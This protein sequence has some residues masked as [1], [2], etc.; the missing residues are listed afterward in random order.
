MEN[1]PQITAP[2]GISLKEN[3]K[4]YL[5]DLAA[6]DAVFAEK[7]ANPKK[8]VEECAK[9]ITGEVY[10]LAG[11]ERC[12]GVTS[13]YVYGLA[14]H[15]YDEEEVKIRPVGGFS[16]I[17]SDTEDLTEEQKAEREERVQAEMRVM[18]AERRAKDAKRK[19]REEAEAVQADSLFGDDF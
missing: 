16:G 6:K 17:V 15:Y 5:D 14:V 4:R 2:K 19:S 7:Y 10:A 1:T 13:D 3:L 12:I 8:S 9:Y 11:N 18:R